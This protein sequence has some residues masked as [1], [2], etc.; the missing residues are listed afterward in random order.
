RRFQALSGM[1]GRCENALVR[2]SNADSRS[3]SVPA[4]IDEFEFFLEKEWTDGFP[5][6]TPTE[7]R[8]RRMLQGTSQDSDEIIGY[9]PPAGEVMSVRDGA[10]HALMAGCRP[11]YL[12][13]VLGAMAQILRDEF[14]M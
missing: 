11:E 5:V 10:I 12:P 9:V 4:A 6:V 1:A 8:V 13:V 7:E 14:N 3:Y 2:R